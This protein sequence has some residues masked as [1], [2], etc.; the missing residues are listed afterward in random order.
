MNTKAA[1]EFEPRKRYKTRG[2]A[3]YFGVSTETVCDWISTKKLKGAIFVGRTYEV[4][5]KELNEF[6]SKRRV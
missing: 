3:E 1:P 5:G 6:I 2:I 4:L